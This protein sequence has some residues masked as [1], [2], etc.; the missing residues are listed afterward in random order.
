MPY[1][2]SPT[3]APLF[4]SL[5][6]PSSQPIK[7]RSDAPISSTS[8]NPSRPPLS[9]NQIGVIVVAATAE[10][11]LRT[12]LTN[13]QNRI[14][15]AEHPKCSTLKPE[16]ITPV[17]AYQRMSFD[18]A[19]SL[20]ELG[21]SGKSDTFFQN[22]RKGSPF[23]FNGIWQGN[24]TVSMIRPVQRSVV[25][26]LTDYL[27]TLPFMDSR[28]VPVIVTAIET[29]IITPLDQFQRN[30]A[31][32]TKKPSEKTF[33]AAASNLSTL[34]N[35]GLAGLFRNLTFNSVLVVATR[36]FPEQRKENPI[37]FSAVTSQFAVIASHAFDTIQFKVS[38]DTNNVK[39]GIGF[40][41]IGKAAKSIYMK[42]GLMGFAS[43]M[44]L[45]MAAVGGGCTVSLS[46]YSYFCNP[47]QSSEK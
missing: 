15:N 25:Y 17:K 14:Q 32:P 4:G 12:P 13:I 33:R 40:E 46:I 23:F 26:G 36:C 8:P 47:E 16:V 42:N 30:L 31:D 1:P 29:A 2:I 39:F 10:N 37:L 19:A 45:R 24:K 27:Q 43:A 38:R 22:T 35:T 7:P 18:A 3:F 20:R 28:V 44:P 41:A 34:T 11:I 6:T 5:K 21:V 9:L